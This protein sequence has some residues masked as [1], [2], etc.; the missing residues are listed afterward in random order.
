MPAR[1]TEIVSGHYYHVF[2][3]S[4]YGL[5]LFLNERYYRR[6]QLTLEFYLL[7]NQQ[8]SLS[9][10]LAKG[11]EFRENLRRDWMKKSRQIR[12]LSYCLMPNHFHLLIYQNSD[13]GI[14]NYLNQIQN[15]YAHYYNTKNHRYGPVFSGRFKAVLI[16]S[17]EQLIHVSRYI[18]LNPIT[19][20]LVK[21]TD[22]LVNYSWSSWNEYVGELQ[23]ISL[24]D[25]KEILQYFKNIKSYVDFVKS[26][27]QFQRDIKEAGRM[28]IDET[29]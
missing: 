3:R 28:L 23:W 1:Q 17:Q 20:Y 15:S 22:E 10:F 19:A 4:P 7:E 18:H 27:V 2:N 21:N 26:D 29:F 6:M 5:E 24:C 8:I 14:Q 9:K 25:V 11:K 12:V 16:E 13:M